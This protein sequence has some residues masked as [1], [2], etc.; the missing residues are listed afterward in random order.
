MF[1]YSLKIIKAHNFYLI[2]LVKEGENTDNSYGLHKYNYNLILETD[3]LSQ[4]DNFIMMFLIMFPIN[5]NIELSPEIIYKFESTSKFCLNNLVKESKG[6]Q[7]N[8]QG[9]LSEYNSE[10]QILEKIW[11]KIEKVLLLKTIS[12]Y[13]AK[14]NYFLLT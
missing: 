13:E 1:L 4:S 11:I 5:V 14:N 9:K 8:I 6:R 3:P 10:I 7:S 2:P 12:P